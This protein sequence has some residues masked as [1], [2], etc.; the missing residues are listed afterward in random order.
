VIFGQEKLH[1]CDSRKPVTFKIYYRHLNNRTPALLG[2]AEFD[3]DALL[4]TES[5]CCEVNLPVFHSKSKK[6]MFGRLKIKALLGQGNF[7]TKK[8]ASQHKDTES[9]T[10][11][12]QTIP[13]TIVSENM[14]TAVAPVASEPHKLLEGSAQ[15]T[16]SANEKVSYKIW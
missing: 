12:S 4:K 2:C 6:E 14:T 10:S 11:S 1:S 5:L 9:V 16:V 7:L 15:S 8:P 13:R 3:W